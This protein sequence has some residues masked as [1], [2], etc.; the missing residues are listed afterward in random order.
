MS[1]VWR[2]K[3]I[4]VLGSVTVEPPYTPASCRGKDENALARVKK[5]VR[6]CG[7][8]VEYCGCSNHVVVGPQVSLEGARLKDFSK[9]SQ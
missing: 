2:G 3:N 1:C 4:E 8:I 9:D 6:G 7:W 5:V